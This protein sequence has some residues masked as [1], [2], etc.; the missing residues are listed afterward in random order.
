MSAY[1]PTETIELVSRTGARKGRARADKVFLGSMSAGCLLG[2]AAGASLMAMAVPW[3]AEN[4][5]GMVK[6]LCACVFPMALVLIMLTGGELFTGSTMF[7]GVAVLHKRLPIKN[8]LLHWLLCFWGNFAGCIFVMFV[9][10]AGGGIF[11]QEPYKGQVISFVTAKQLTP[12]WHQIFIRGIGCNWLVCLGIFMGM[13]GKDVAS[14]A[15]GMYIPI[16]VFV[17]LG[18]DH[19]AANMF[20]IPLGMWLGTPNLT[21]GL[22]I[23]KGMVPVALGN[24]IG[25][26]I[27][28]G[29]FYYYM[30]VWGEPDIAVDGAY[31]TARLEEGNLDTST[32]SATLQSN[33]PEVS[34]NG[35]SAAVKTK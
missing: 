7:T 20:F 32:S 6:L 19:I 22:Y 3:Y 31:Y 12:Q 1:T 30:F 27:F 28:V 18:F 11:E 14:K 23:W 15:V 13:Q 10:M 34:G 4:A 5:P 2:L 24:L 33:N 16:F 8:M 25:G 26:T 21:I 9:F 29:G 17:M 35:R